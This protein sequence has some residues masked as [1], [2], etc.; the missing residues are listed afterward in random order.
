MK[1]LPIVFQNAKKIFVIDND[2]STESLKLKSKREGTLW[3][4]GNAT[5]EGKDYKRTLSNPENAENL[6]S[7]TVK[8]DT[9][10]TL[11]RS[12]SL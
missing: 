11:N 9:L 12:S 4:A 3:D 1:K 5:I 8:F 2:Y 6:N 7:N 10:E